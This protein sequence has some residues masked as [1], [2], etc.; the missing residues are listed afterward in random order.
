MSR[1]ESE[2]SSGTKAPIKPI[3]LGM[4]GLGIGGGMIL[5]GA[6]KMPEVEVFA[7]ADTR[8]SA[9]DAFQTR[10]EGRVYDSEKALCEDPDVEVVW[11]ATPNN[12]HSE[13]VVMA[14]EHGKHVV[15]DKP[16]AVHVEQCKRMVDAAEKNGV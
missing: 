2:A 3:K 5:A 1:A 12:M 4:A 11:V 9:L 14:A 16:L 10:Y 7:A 8:K 13:H 6:E 15:S